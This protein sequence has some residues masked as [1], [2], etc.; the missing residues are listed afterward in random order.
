MIG[1]YAPDTGGDARHSG[2][3]GRDRVLHSLYTKWRRCV[4]PTIFMFFDPNNKKKLKIAWI[5]IGIFIIISMVFVYAPI[6]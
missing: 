2:A 4:P 6:F 1:A 5:I 3:A